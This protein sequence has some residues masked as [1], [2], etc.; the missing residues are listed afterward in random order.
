[1][2]KGGPHHQSLLARLFTQ[3]QDPIRPYI[4]DRADQAGYLSLQSVVEDHVKTVF[5][6]RGAISM[7]PPLLLPIGPSDVDEHLAV[8]YLDRQGNLVAL[9]TDGFLPFARLV[10]RRGINRIKRFGFC[11]AFE[12]GIA[13]GQPRSVHYAMFDIVSMDHSLVRVF[14]QS[15]AMIL[16]L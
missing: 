3:P 7:E 11:Q 9:P 5:H 12:Q 6:G 8:M 16:T 10:V 15:G 4:Y 2:D 13:G 1:M 14:S